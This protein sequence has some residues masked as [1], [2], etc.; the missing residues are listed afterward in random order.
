MRDKT[1]ILFLA[2]FVLLSYYLLTH[3]IDILLP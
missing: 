2:L 3:S 1:L